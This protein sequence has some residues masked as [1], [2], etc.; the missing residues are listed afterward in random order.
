MP[1]E[2]HYSHLNRA[3]RKGSAQDRDRFAPQILVLT[4]A[5]QKLH[6]YLGKGSRNTFLSD[7]RRAQL[8]PGAI[9]SDPGF[10]SAVVGDHSG[11][12]TDDRPNTVLD[13]E[14][15]NRGRLVPSPNQTFG[16]AELLF[17][18]GARFRVKQVEQMK[19]GVRAA[20]V[21]IE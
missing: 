5:L 20:L 17:L 10:S 11:Y 13:I 2:F 7:E 15:K 1:A 16:G 14:S 3:L 21:E 6:G 18:P 9:F 8:V 4:S 12:W 19:W